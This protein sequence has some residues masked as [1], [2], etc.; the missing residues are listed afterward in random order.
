MWKTSWQRDTKA[1]SSLAT[2]F[3]LLI[4]LDFVRTCIRNRNCRHVNSTF[5]HPFFLR[6][7]RI[8]HLFFYLFIS[9]YLF[10]ILLTIVVLYVIVRC[11]L[12]P[13]VYFSGAA[14]KRNE[15]T[16]YEFVFAT[17]EIQIDFTFN[18]YVISFTTI[19]MFIKKWR[20]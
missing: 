20:N 11:N 18:F 12:V 7:Q 17:T 5:L 2:F 1:Q 13:S 9:L 3:Y 19:I 10:I 14:K 6:E 8:L 16:R 15:C 4:F